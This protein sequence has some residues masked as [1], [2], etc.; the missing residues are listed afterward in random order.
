TFSY[1]VSDGHGGSAS[2][3]VTLDIAGAND[4]ATF[5]GDAHSS[6]T[7]DVALTAI[8]LLAAIDPDDGE[9]GFQPEIVAGTY[10]RLQID[11]GGG[12][13]YTLEQNAAPA[14]QALTTSSAPLHDV[15][16][17]HAIDGG[18]TSI[19]ID[20]FGVNDPA[21]IGGATIGTVTNAGDQAASGVHPL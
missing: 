4:P 10:G 14:V 1:T 2:Q 15:L 9:S 13:V 21:V 8:G 11:A 12:W 17:V 19:R 18:A 16:A 3:T 20:I 7:E 6:V 5:A